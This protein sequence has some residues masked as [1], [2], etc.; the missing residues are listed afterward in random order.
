MAGFPS[1]LI[2]E[3]IGLRDERSVA[4]AGGDVVPRPI[5]VTKPEHAPATVMKLDLHAA[6]G[7]VELQRA[8]VGR[9]KLVQRIIHEDV[10]VTCADVDRVFDRDVGQHLMGAV[11]EDD[12]RSVPMT[13]ST[14]FSR[15]GERVLNRAAAR[16]A[17]AI[18]SF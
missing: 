10:A 2:D 9:L 7:G 18:I 13:L 6:F 15:M 8:L 17:I 11:A 12:C 14:Q 1:S 16:F 4:I 5:L 3:T